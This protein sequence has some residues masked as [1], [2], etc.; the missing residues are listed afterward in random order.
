MNDI[1]F[2]TLHYL[3]IWLNT[4]QFLK[5]SEIS[6]KTLLGSLRHDN[7]NN[8]YLLINSCLPDILLSI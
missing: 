6:V 5:D 7:N 4:F 2:K 8:N 1:I 3:N